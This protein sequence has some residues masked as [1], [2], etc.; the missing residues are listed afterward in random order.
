M[1]PDPPYLQ[2][3]GRVNW[4]GLWTLYAKEV[5]RFMKVGLQTVAAPVI[6]TLI[7]MMVFSFSLGSWRPEIE[8]IPFSQFLAP[9]LIMMALIQNAF[10]N[11]SS[12]LLIAKMQGNIVD[13]L[14]IPLSAAEFTF[15]MCMSGVTRGLVVAVSVGLCM[16]VF[17][18]LGVAHWWAMIFFSVGASLFLSL[19]GLLIGIWS[20][21][22]D[23]L[24]A[25]TSFIIIPLSMLSGTFYSI[26]SMP[27]G[28]YV[29][30][31][32][33]PFF[34]MIDGFRYGLIGYAETNILVGV[35]LLVFLNVA[36]WG[37]CY[38]LLYIGWRMRM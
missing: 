18:P 32:Y 3:R 20:H 29:A 9:G 28:L 8:G 17:V 13:Y 6:T 27:Y 38:H 23:H 4:I 30:S 22:F 35:W 14:M 11:T 12:S 2:S 34:Y 7:F 24:Q 26:S 37:L 10:A 19:L 1:Q 16:A 25:I 31:T 15:A 21:K 5:R 36:L 33:N